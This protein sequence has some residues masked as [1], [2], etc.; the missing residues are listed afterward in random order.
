MCELSARFHPTSQTLGCQNRSLGER[1]L[2]SQSGG[3]GGLVWFVVVW[4]GSPTK[5]GFCLPPESL[6][7]K[8]PSIS[9]LLDALHLKNRETHV[10]AASE[11]PGGIYA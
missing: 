7:T 5:T 3:S 4:F 8:M 11:L 9:R 10:I 1:E 6:G 2:S